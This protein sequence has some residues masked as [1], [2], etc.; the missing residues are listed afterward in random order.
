MCRSVLLFVVCGG[1]IA[2]SEAAWG[3]MNRS[4]TGRT[5]VSG[6]GG[7]GTSGA[8]TNRTQ[9]MQQGGQLSS[10]AAISRDASAFVGDSAGSFLSR[11]GSQG[12]MR[13]G[14]TGV[15]GLGGLGTMGAMGMM[16]GMTGRSGMMGRSGFGTNQFGQT[17]LGGRAG[18]AGTGTS[19]VR[20]PLR[21][22][23]EVSRSGATEISARLERRIPRIPGLESV[24]GVAVT[25]DGQTAVLQGAVASQTQR[26]LIG[27][28]ALLEPGVSEV[29]NELVVS[30]SGPNLSP[31]LVPANTP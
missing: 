17:N 14:M 31:E 16:G 23:F 20:T 22:G 30:S 24:A 18:R 27:R 10:A 5:S 19:Q 15:S 9:G 3:Q 25:M 12:T 2:Y 13:G 8:R 29:R 1:L 28:L 7:A 4:T 11:S 21:L 26:D 6:L